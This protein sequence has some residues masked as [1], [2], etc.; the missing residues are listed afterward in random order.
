MRSHFRYTKQEKRGILF[1]LLLIA[2][3]QSGFYFIDLSP[4]NHSTPYFSIDS[5]AQ[6]FVDSVRQARQKIATSGMRPFNPN[7]ITDYKGYILGMSADELDRL[8]N[9][10]KNKQ[11]VQTPE[12]FQKVTGISDSLLNQINPYFNFP[13]FKYATPTKRNKD[14]ISPPIKDLN[15]VSKEELQVISGIGPVLSA[16]IIR[17]RESL[18][19]FLAT[20]Q[21]LDVYGLDPEVA[22]RAMKVFK[23]LHPPKGKKISINTASVS[24]L[25]S[26]TYINWALAEQIVAY[27]NTL[28]RFDSIEQLTKIEDFP[29]ERIHRIKLYLAL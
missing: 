25:A 14:E 26:L 10:R 2:A 6:V 16:R 15:T 9:F 28:G 21:L 20:E 27:R 24:E 3:L 12:E 22:Q 13:V 17:F 5:L 4:Q 8:Y 18:G 7:F 11:Y 29:T 1:L 19:G 23:V